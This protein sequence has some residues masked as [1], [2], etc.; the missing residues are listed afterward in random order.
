VVVRVPRI[1][2]YDDV[3]ALEHSPGVVVRFAERADEVRGADLVILPGSKNTATD[4][5]WLR[6]SGIAKVIEERALAREPVLG[7]CG[8]CQM[9]GD[10][11]EDPFGIESSEPRVAGLGLLPLVTRFARDKTTARVVARMAHDSFLGAGS[12]EEVAG[13]EIH[14]GVIEQTTPCGSPFEL[15]SRNGSPVRVADGAV[16]ATGAIVGTMLHGIFENEAFRSRVLDRLRARRNLSAPSVTSAVA[17]KQAE[18][19]RLEASLRASIDCELLWRIA[20]LR[21]AR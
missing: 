16:D 20:R 4:L 15:I 5:A 8:G 9:L 3:E 11:I 6:A 7:I 13:Y 19:D 14:M 1:S 10:A 17:P 2:N 18:Y 21:P 12:S